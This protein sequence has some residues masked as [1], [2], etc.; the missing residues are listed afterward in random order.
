MIKVIQILCE[1][2][3]HEGIDEGNLEYDINDSNI[4]IDNESEDEEHSEK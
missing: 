4:V 1:W 2:Y 3:D